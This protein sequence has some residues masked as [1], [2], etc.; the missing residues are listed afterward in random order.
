MVSD[1][2]LAAKMTVEAVW[3]ELIV[4]SW[5]AVTSEALV[6]LLKLASEPVSES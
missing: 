5:E 1:L 2:A 3:P 6:A 4:S